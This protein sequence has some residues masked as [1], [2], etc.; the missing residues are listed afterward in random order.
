MLEDTIEYID[1]Y[2]TRPLTIE[3]AAQI[4]K[5]RKWTFYGHPGQTWILAFSPALKVS[6]LI[7]KSEFDSLRAAG[8][9]EKYWAWKDAIKEAS[10]R[11]VAEALNGEQALQHVVAA[12]AYFHKAYPTSKLNDDLQAVADIIYKLVLPLENKSRKSSGY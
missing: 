2:Q 6:V 8:L 7:L 4:A 10:N 1:D 9:W 3:E 11:A 5:E 12:L